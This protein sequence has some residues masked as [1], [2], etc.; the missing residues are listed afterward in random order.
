MR[1]LNFQI[2]QFGL[3]T[4]SFGFT[5]LRYRMWKRY[6]LL[7]LCISCFSDDLEFFFLYRSF[8]N[9]AKHFKGGFDS[10]SIMYIF[11]EHKLKELVEFSAD[12]GKYWC[13]RYLLFSRYDDGIKMD[14]EGWFSVT[15]E[16]IARHHA[17]RCG[18]GIILD[19]FTGVG[20]NAIQFAQR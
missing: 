9:I 4:I 15:P 14:E 5:N 3:G 19:C 8:G 1:L 20:G 16:S 2:T 10:L 11:A 7:C 18:S 17:C 13:Q 6:S 12:I